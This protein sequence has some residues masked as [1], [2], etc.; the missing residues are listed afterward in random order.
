MT[1]PTTH[2]LERSLARAIALAGDL[3][4]ESDLAADRDPRDLARFRYRTNSL[5]QDLQKIHC[6]FLDIALELGTDLATPEPAAGPTNEDP[7]MSVAEEAIA[8]VM[9]QREEI[10]TAFVAKYGVGPGALEQVEQHMPD[11]SSR[12][13]VRLRSTVAIAAELEES[14]D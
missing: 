10:L 5:L 6:C 4:C 9:A 11:G 2:E 13:F 12:W 7:V 14:N 3:A 1:D 8:A